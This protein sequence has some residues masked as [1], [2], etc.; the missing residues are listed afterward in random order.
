MSEPE[1]EPKLFESRSRSRSGNKKFRLH[2][3][4]TNT[5]CII[6]FHF[7][8]TLP[9]SAVEE[10][11]SSILGHDHCDCEYGFWSQN[12]G[13]VLGEVHISCLNSISASRLHNSI[14]SAVHIIGNQL[15]LPS[16]Q[17]FFGEILLSMITVHYKTVM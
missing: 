13:S 17:P 16:P 4:V 14:L 5:Y 12:Q 6:P 3:T 11:S 7:K 15:W 8:V 10:M 1:P 2:N 9:T